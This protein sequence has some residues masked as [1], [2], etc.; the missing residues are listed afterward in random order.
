VDGNRIFNV[1][2]AVEIFI[3]LDILI[4][5]LR[6]DLI[7][8]IGFG[9]EPGGAGDRTNHRREGGG[10]NV[11]TDDLVSITAQ[12]ADE[13]LTQMARTSGYQDHSVLHLAHNKPHQRSRQFPPRQIRC[14]GAVPRSWCSP[15]ET[16]RASVQRVNSHSEDR[17]YE[18]TPQHVF[19]AMRA[20]RQIRCVR[21]G[22]SNGRARR[23][24]NQ[25]SPTIRRMLGLR[26]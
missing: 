1:D 20:R 21:S 11:E 12:G 4:G 22:R 5:V 2:T 24:R 26:Q 19:A 15:H 10:N 7:E 14:S 17:S 18:L 3:D 6:A 13:R 23:R 25:T 8:V 16:R 9:E